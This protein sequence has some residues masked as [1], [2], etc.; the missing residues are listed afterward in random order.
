MSVSVNEI[1]PNLWLGNME[2]SQNEKFM[3]KNN[4]QLIVNATDILPC[5]FKNIKYVRISIN[6][7]GPTNDKD[8]IDNVILLRQLPDIVNLI[9]D[10]LIKG[11]PVFVHC[12]A[13]IQRSASVVLCY[14]MTYIYRQYDKN[15]NLKYSLRHLIKNRPVAFYGGKNVSFKPA[16]SQYLLSL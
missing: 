6:D 10:H 1:I 8:Q 16:I 15:E 12:R 4:I 14:L 13:G 9:H 5:E 11:R 3:K 2:A 7:P